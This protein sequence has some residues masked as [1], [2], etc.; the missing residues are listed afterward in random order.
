MAQFRVEQFPR[1][2]RGELAPVYLVAGEE[3]LLIEE[4]LGALRARARELGFSEREVLHADTGFDWGRLREARDNLSLFGERRLIEVRLPG[5]KPGTDGGSLIQAYCKS[6]PADTLL[7]VICGRLDG[8]QR[9][10]A[11]ASAIERAGVSV[12]AWPV[13][14]DQLPGWLERRLRERGLTPTRDAVS[15]LAERSEGNLMAAA[16]EVEKLL[17]IHGPGALDAEQVR[18]ATASSARFDVFDLPAAALDGDVARVV[19]VH[20]VLRELGEEPTLLLW[21]LARDIRVI[22]DLQCA[23]A[24]RARP[25]DVYRRH[26]IW[27]AQQARY[28]RV[29]H[30][31]G[32][33]R[34][35][36]LVER[37]GAVDAVIKGAARGRA[38]DELLQ[39]SVEM[40]WAAA[41]RDAGSQ[42]A[43]SKA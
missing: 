29:A 37:A 25:D 42:G 8:R 2:L 3:P 38:W 21:A 16:Q 34:W 19:R 43:A 36:A 26:R 5:G 10:S 1:H 22:V 6:P 28:W 41:G 31:G 9:R 23:R 13:R 4:A 30:Q 39:L 11:W 15:V 20:T 7:V 27:K 14:L 33:A 17:L 40:A 32:E 18:S 35:L 24:S 12:Y